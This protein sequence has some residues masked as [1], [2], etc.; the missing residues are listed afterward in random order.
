MAAILLGVMILRR[1][2]FSLVVGLFVRSGWR[3]RARRAAPR[4]RLV[5][6]D[7][8]H[9]GLCVVVL[10]RALRHEFGS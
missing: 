7:G 1:C 5:F 8:A 4:F 3:Y 10:V 6:G 2:A 9:C